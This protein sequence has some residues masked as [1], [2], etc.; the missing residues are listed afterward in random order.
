VTVF[1][2]GPTTVVEAEG[3]VDGVT[4]GLMEVVAAVPSAELGLG[5]FGGRRR[6]EAPGRCRGA[7]S[8]AAREAEAWSMNVGVRDRGPIQNV[9]HARKQNHLMT[10]ITLLKKKSKREDE[11]CIF[12]YTFHVFYSNRL[13]FQDN[14]ST[15]NCI[16]KIHF[17]TL[18][19]K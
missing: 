10:N 19:K 16:C 4:L 1:E 5:A 17:I 15:F 14:S 18:I 12:I 3:D 8:W 6:R 2:G 13:E 11:I 9:Q 7:G